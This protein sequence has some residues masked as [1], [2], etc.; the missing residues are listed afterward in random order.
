MP[1][2]VRPIRYYC[3]P[4]DGGPFFF[5]LTRHLEL[6]TRSSLMYKEQTG[7]GLGCRCTT[8]DKGDAQL[9]AR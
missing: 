3:I 4:L 6:Q 2:M 1:P 5:F 8:N 9:C 7:P